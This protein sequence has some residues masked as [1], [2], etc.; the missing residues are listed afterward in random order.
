MSEVRAAH[1]D[2]EWRVDARERCAHVESNKGGVSGPHVRLSVA[3]SWLALGLGAWR[4]PHA[5]PGTRLEGLAPAWAPDI[6][7]DA[8]TRAPETLDSQSATIA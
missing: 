3:R 6:G 2:G 5:H 7:I 1:C 4:V 8:T